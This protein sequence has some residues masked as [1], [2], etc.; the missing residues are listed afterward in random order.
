MTDSP[1]ALCR[2]R[3]TSRRSR[4]A[5]RAARR[6]AK[7][8]VG[9]IT[10]NGSA[11]KTAARPDRDPDRAG[12]IAAAQPAAAALLAHEDLALRLPARRCGGHGRGS[13]RRCRRPASRVQAAGDCHLPQLRR[14]RHARASSGLRHQRLR[15]DRRR[16]VGVGSE[17]P[18]HE[19]RGGHARHPRQGCP[20]RTRPD[21]GAPLSRDHGDH[22]RHAGARR[23]VPRPAH[24]EPG[25]GSGDRRWSSV[26]CARRS[27]FL[28]H[29]ADRLAQPWQRPRS[30]ASRMRRRSSITRL[31]KRRRGLLRR[32]HG[33]CSRTTAPRS[34]P[35][36]RR[37]SSATVGR[38][39]LQGGGRRLCRHAVRRPAHGLG[40]R[41]GALPAVQGGDALGARGSCRRKSLPASWRTGGARPAAAAGGERHPAGLRHRARPAATS[42]S[43]SCATP[44]SSRSSRP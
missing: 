10:R 13:C 1:S 18:G 4:T 8:C 23:L 33:R 17:A 21:R 32:R 29:A 5:P 44:R 11:H 43:A 14:L 30:R 25:Q 19:L 6:C 12:R 36:G 24:R 35:S 3:P 38:C 34:R 16:A 41:R 37:C 39:R 20:H 42:T 2:H 7:T 9:A 26:P 27:D 22:R 28:T 31:G 15:R 40:Q